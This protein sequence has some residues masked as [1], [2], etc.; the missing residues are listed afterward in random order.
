L[1]IPTVVG[2]S[3]RNISYFIDSAFNF[4]AVITHLFYYVTQIPV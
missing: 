3:T 1:P 4:L 2:E